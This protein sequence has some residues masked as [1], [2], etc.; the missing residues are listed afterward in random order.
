MQ[1]GI[2]SFGFGLESIGLMVVRFPRIFAVVVMGVLAIGLLGIP[3]LGF[4]GNIL[5]ILSSNNPAFVAYQGVRR[6]FR[7]FSGDLGVIVRADDLFE[8]EGFEKLREFHLEL[9]LLEDATGVFS[10]FSSSEIDAETG[11]MRPSIP[12]FIEPGDD[13]RAI[14]AEAART[15]PLVAQ[16]S[17]PEANAALI[18][19]ETGMSEDGPRRPEPA[20]VHAL[21]DEIR[22]LAPPG[23]QVD[24]VGYPLMR[25]DA[26]QAVVNDQILMVG[27]GIGMVLAISLLTFRAVVPA[28]ICAAPAMAAVFLLL[29]VYGL[30]G[31]KVNYLST[32]LPTI[33]MVLALAD[34]IMLYHSWSARRREGMD[35]RSATKAALLR[36]GPANSMTSITT[37]VAFGSFAF[38]GNPALKTLAFLGSSA[39]MVAFLAVMI[40]VPLLLIFFGDRAG[41]TAR[42]NLFDRAGPLVARFALLRPAVIAAVAATTA[43]LLSFGHYNVSE[44]HHMTRQL[45][46]DSESYRGELL[47]R[48]IFGGTAPIYLVVPVPEGQEWSDD[49]A[50]DALS[51]AEAVFGE[52]LGPDQVFSLAR[53]RAAGLTSE[54]MRA[55]LGEAP[56]NLRGRFLSSDL[57]SYL[58]TGAA[59]FG[60]T[61]P[62]AT[63]LADGTVAEL[64]GQG[65]SG[66]RVTGYPVLL[67]IEIP[68]IVNA[69]R[70]SLVIAI[71]LGIAVIAAASRAPVVSVAAFLPNLIPILAIE[72]VLWLIDEPMDVSHVVA[73]TI[74]FGISIDNAIH[75]INSFL[76]NLEDGMGDS[77]AI[78]AALVEVSP[79]L[80]TATVMFIAGSA[81][82]LFSTMPSVVNLGFLIMAT[83]G[84]ALISNLAFLP[85]LILTL[86]RLTGRAS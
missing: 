74:A 23:L 12:E 66:A 5:S 41:A 50:L 30:S 72:T 84:A 36:I 21:V 51:R 28:L 20:V 73:L 52:R 24:F 57:K 76:A 18:S 3:K 26:V 55:M 61:G 14:V 8:A 11:E 22:A 34:T 45:P 31:A 35:A 56:D 32:A 60:M 43:V 64:A 1:T 42:V 46:V 62:E 37:A 17:R 54:R 59:P 70:T 44:E 58:V 13:I 48:D 82:T 86:R 78:R 25:A 33:A 19:V 85:A 80:V 27:I 39:V 15:N 75:V 68:A 38:G 81:G 16:L 40:V 10:V 2:K 63:S 29:G 4:D 6:D 65:I 53:V 9:T 79:A 49:A 47:A 67:A 69:L 7:D 77:A 83:L 71:V